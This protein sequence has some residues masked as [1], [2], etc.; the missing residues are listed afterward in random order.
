MEF[1]TDDGL[2]AEYRLYCLNIGHLLTHFSR[3]ENLLTS[4]LKL[5]LALNIGSPNEPRSMRIASAIYGSMRFKASRDT[6]K[7]LLEAEGAPKD[8]VTFVESLFTQI[9]HIESLRDKIAHQLVVPAHA[10]LGGYWQVSDMVNTRNIRNLQV[11]VF[12]TDALEAAAMDLDEIGN[13][14]GNKPVNDRLF[15]QLPDFKLPSWRYKP[16]MLKL[17]PHS[18]LKAHFGQ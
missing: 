1:S 13:L 11:W 9:S 14:L 5:H 3:L 6:I 4:V 18:K 17:V 8:R 7:R 10:D 12:D 16:S 15:D 2:N